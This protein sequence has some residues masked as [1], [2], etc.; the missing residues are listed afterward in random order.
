MSKL[1]ATTVEPEGAT[2]N[3]DLGGSG[4]SVVVNSDAIKANTF[5]DAGGNTLWVSDGS[6]VLSSLNSGLAGGG[7]TL[8][9]TTEITTSTANVTYNSDTITS[10][11]DEYWVIGYGIRPA[12][13]GTHF[14][15]QCG[16][17]FNTQWTNVYTNQYRSDGGTPAMGDAYTQWQATSLCII[18]PDMGADET[19][20]CGNFIAQICDPTSTSVNKNVILQ[21]VLH[22]DGTTHNLT[23]FESVVHW[24]TNSALT[25][26][27]FQ[28][29]GGDIA[30]GTFKV[31]GLE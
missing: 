3:L 21:G 15:F 20:R 6:G 24:E 12:T 26:W 30:S 14:K 5:K 4:D 18:F 28:Y 8:L 9:D 23:H 7:M 13:N 17:S 1:R 29:D 19:E 16:P 10:T 25:D 2:T 27:R 11:Y 22:Q 31:Y